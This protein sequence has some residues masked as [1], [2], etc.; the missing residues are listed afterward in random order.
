MPK[1][2]QSQQSWGTLLRIDPNGKQVFGSINKIR[3]K[4]DAFYS[5]VFCTNNVIFSF[6][7]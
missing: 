6:K 3:S 1:C 5:Q 7:N 4:D 2:L